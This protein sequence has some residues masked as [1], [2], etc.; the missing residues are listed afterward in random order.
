MNDLGDRIVTVFRAAPVERA[1]EAFRIGDRNRMFVSRLSGT[2]L[3]RETVALAGEQRV[4]GLPPTLP[5]R[6]TDLDR[7]L[8]P[9]L[10][11]NWSD[12]PLLDLRLVGFRQTDAFSFPKSSQSRVEVRNVE[13][14]VLPPLRES[15][16]KEVI[17]EQATVL[18]AADRKPQLRTN[19]VEPVQNSDS[20]DLSVLGLGGQRFGSRSS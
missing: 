15:P 4:V 14:P 9:K 10:A 17:C 20:C 19:G 5:T 12:E 11:Q 18:N 2:A 6:K 3:G 13:R 1:P 8:E 16:L 7:V